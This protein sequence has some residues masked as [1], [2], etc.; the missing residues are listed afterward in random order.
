MRRGKFFIAIF[1]LLLFSVS[2]NSVLASQDPETDRVV[3]H[4]ILAQWKDS[5]QVCRIDINHEGLPTGLE[6]IS[7]CGQEIFDLF[8]QTPPCDFIES[9]TTENCEGLYL[10]QI[11]S[12]MEWSNQEYLDPVLLSFDFPVCDA[13]ISGFY[14]EETP[15]MVVQ[16]VEEY[17]EGVIISVDSDFDDENIRCD[18]VTCSIYLFSTGEYGMNLRI[19]IADKDTEK[20]YEQNFKV[21]SIF[22]EE[23]EDSPRL[24]G[25]WVQVRSQ[26]RLEKVDIINIWGL[27]APVEPP[28]WLALLEGPEELAT[29]VSYYHLAGRMITYGLASP[30]T[31]PSK[32]LTIDGYANE[33]GLSAVYRGMIDWQNQFDNGIYYAADIADISPVLLKNL[34]AKESQFWPENDLVEYEY[35]FGHMTLV[36]ADTLFMWNYNFFDRFCVMEFGYQAGCGF[37]YTTLSEEQRELLI[38]E[39]LTEVSVFCENCSTLIDYSHVNFSIEVFSE[40]LLA[41]STQTANI[42]ESITDEPAGTL[43]SYEDLWRF[44]LANYNGGAG[45]I[46]EAI[47]ATWESD[48]ALTWENVSLNF[49]EECSRVIDYVED[50]APEVENAD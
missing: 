1:I 5:E 18:G 22:L 13:T 37:G 30:G 44:T 21:R 47:E 3:Y 31:C 2:S 28:K 38:D 36:G 12:S 46:S 6:I 17:A 45:C 10:K 11:E 43:S 19:N 49:T 8:F 32:G 33:C 9:G 50:I 20:H 48:V 42:I 34:F 35:G 16:V 40:V 27:E 7:Q 41:Y 23:D 14:C 25:W 29:G 26:H 4:W 24:E 39:L 15:L